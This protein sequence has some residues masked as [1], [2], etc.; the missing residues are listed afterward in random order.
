MTY[1]ELAELF[2]REGGDAQVCFSI[3]SQNQILF[4][5]NDTKKDI[6]GFK[7][8][9]PIKWVKEAQEESVSDELEEA[10]DNALSN[11]LNTHEIVNVR[12]CLEMFRLGAKWQKEQMIAK[13]IDAKLLEGHLIRQKSVTHPLHVGDKVKVIIIKED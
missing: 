7:N 10:A 8:E 11:V 13:A 5:N 3:I 9:E 2:K 1:N 6:I 4:G 12:S